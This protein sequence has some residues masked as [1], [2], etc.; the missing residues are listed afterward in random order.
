MREIWVTLP[1]YGTAA[2]TAALPHSYQSVQYF[3]V[4]KQWC[5]FQ[6]LRFLTCVQILPHVIA[7]I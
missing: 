3:C 4:S 2:A 1:G 5:G 7:I 6:R